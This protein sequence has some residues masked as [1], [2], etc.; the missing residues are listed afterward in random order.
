MSR[1]Y[2]LLAILLLQAVLAT[3]SGAQTASQP[4]PIS[5]VISGGMTLP[6]GEFDD[7]H[8]SGFH[9]DAS[10][11][12]NIPGFPIALRPE[13]S[14]TQF[15][16]EVFTPSGGTFDGT[17][18]LIAAL[19]NFEVPLAAGFYALA[20]GGLLA[21]S[22]EWSV[23]ETS[24]SGLTQVGGAGF[25]FAIGGIRAFVEAR[26]VPHPM[27]KGN[28]GSARRGLSPSLSGWCS[29]ATPDRLSDP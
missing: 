16:F 22:R 2:A 9:Y 24:A 19:A 29:R 21:L 20:G 7:F 6:A 17:T 27:S 14:F 8:D 26:M 25:R 4:K 13:F 23:N 3:R 18:Q 28:S 10:L 1:A 5:F 11:L 15:T 12:L